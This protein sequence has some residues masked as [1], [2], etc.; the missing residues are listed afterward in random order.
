MVGSKSIPRWRFLLI[1]LWVGFAWS[2]DGFARQTKAR[3][4]N[5]VRRIYGLKNLRKQSPNKGRLKTRQ[6]RTGKVDQICASVL[7]WDDNV[8]R[9]STQIYLL[10]TN[11]GTVVSVSSEEFADL[12]ADLGKGSV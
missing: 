8:M 7:D 4:T 5:K 1:V 3:K 2:Q 10:N 9:M 12:R 11:D 6:P